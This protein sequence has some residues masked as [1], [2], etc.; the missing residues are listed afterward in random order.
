VLWHVGDQEIIDGMP[1]GIA[2]L[3]ADGSRQVVKLQ[4]GSLALYAFVMLIGVVSLMT[5]Y[6]LFR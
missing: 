3:A 6:L 1:N 5:V 2:A 4:T